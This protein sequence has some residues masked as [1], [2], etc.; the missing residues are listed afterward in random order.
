M[1]AEIICVGTELLLGQIVN[2]NATF[3]SEQLAQLGIEVYYQTVVGDN[4]KRLLK[5]IELAQTRSDLVIL[6]GGLGPTEDD[7]TKQTVAKFLNKKLLYDQGALQKITD[8]F[9]KSQQEMA[10][11]NRLQAMYFEDARPLKNSTGLALGIYY[12]APD[13]KADFLLLP[14]P[15]NELQPMFLNEV[16][17]LLQAQKSLTSRV[18]RFFGIGESMLVTKLADLIQH[19]TNPTLA[20]YA[21]TNEVTLR[22]TASATSQKQA[23]ELLDHLEEQIKQ[24]VG[25][26]FYGYGDDNSLAQVVVAKLKEKH[27]TISAAESLTGGLFAK[28]LTDVAGVS[29]VFLGSF[30]TYASEIKTKILEIDPQIIQ[31]EGVVSEKVACLMASQ[32]QAKLQTDLAVSFTGV[33][34]PEKLDNQE[35]GTVWIG[36]KFKDQPVKAQKFYFPKTRELVREKSVLTALWWIYQEIK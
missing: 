12:Q 15:P 11:N 2:T 4:E 6:S 22:L 14:G 20:P 23:N 31:R 10:P 36:L 35:A 27:L 28:T 32:T 30:V 5:T 17:P 33:A 21:K 7:L 13:A 19:Q 26:Y 8:F 16:K 9:V 18:L 34:G 1:N 29:A 25:E 24:R 3:L